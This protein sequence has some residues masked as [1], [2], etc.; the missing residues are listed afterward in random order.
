MAGY[1][2]YL[3]SVDFTGF[4]FPIRNW[5][6]AQG[7]LMPISQ[8]SALFSLLATYWGG[9]GRTTF[10]LPN[11]A[12]RVPVGQGQAPGLSYRTLGQQYGVEAVTLT[13]SQ[14]PAHT[15]PVQ[16]GGTGSSDSSSG[17]ALQGTTTGAGGGTA[18]SAA[19]GSNQP[20]GILPPSLVLAPQVALYGIYPT[21]D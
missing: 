2:D 20:V 12:G 18:T 9:D 1:E 21:R 8:N 15:H 13:N 6:L 16:L 14:L 7:Q 3:G 19:T 11:L 17:P 10:A 5:A 4:P